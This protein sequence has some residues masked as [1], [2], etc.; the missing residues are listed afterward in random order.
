MDIFEGGR[1]SYNEGYMGRGQ[2]DGM[3]EDWAGVS[4]GDKML[5]VFGDSR[6]VGQSTKQA[7]I[8]ASV[9]GGQGGRA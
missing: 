5:A 3:G 8:S 6:D 7:G 1:H 4:A 9:W 2:G